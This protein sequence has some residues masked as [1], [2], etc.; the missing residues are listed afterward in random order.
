MVM[1]EPAQA[2]R[3]RIVIDLDA[4]IECRSCAA[5]C[6]YGHNEIPVVHFARV[7]AAMLPAMCRQCLDAPCVAA[8]PADAMKQDDHGAVYRSVF[9]CRGCGSCAWACPFGMLDRTTFSGQIAR[10]DL[11]RD[12]LDDGQSPRCVESCPTAA[13]RFAEA[14]ESEADGLVVLGSRTIGHHPI[15]R[16]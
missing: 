14:S 11:C 16:R 1:L 9:A 6:F 4:C 15:K 12:R 13:L 10:C 7:G 3:S 2:V 8:C 5:A